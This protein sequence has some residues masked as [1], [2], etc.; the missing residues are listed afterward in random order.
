M[1]C[2]HHTALHSIHQSSFLARQVCC[3]HNICT[4]TLD[5]NKHKQENAPKT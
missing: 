3:N 1:T 5:C 4:A 2:S